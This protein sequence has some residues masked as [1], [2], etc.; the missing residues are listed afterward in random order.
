MVPPCRVIFEGHRCTVRA[1]CRLGTNSSE[2]FFFG[3]NDLPSNPGYLA[4]LSPFGSHAVRYTQ[5]RQGADLAWACAC[6]NANVMQLHAFCQVNALY[7]A[8]S[9]LGLPHGS[10]RAALSLGCATTPDSMDHLLV[11]A[12]MPTVCSAPPLRPPPAPL[13]CLR[14][15]AQIPT[16]LPPSS[17]RHGPKRS[18]W[19]KLRLKCPQWLLALLAL[20]PALT[21]VLA[22]A[23]PSCDPCCGLSV[24][25]FH[26]M[27]GCVQLTYQRCPCG[28][29]TNCLRYP[30]VYSTKQR[31]T[32]GAQAATS[33]ATL[34]PYKSPPSHLC[35]DPTQRVCGMHV[36]HIETSEPEAALAELQQGLLPTKA[37]DAP[38]GSPCPASACI[39]DKTSPDHTSDQPLQPLSAAT[40][41]AEPTQQGISDADKQRILMLMAQ[42]LRSQSCVW[43]APS[44]CSIPFFS[45][46]SSEDDFDDLTYRCLLIPC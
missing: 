17:R 31:S 6:A 34:S 25:W 10:I 39:Q 35:S 14:S 16:C 40:V 45:Q 38:N 8:L 27:G 2:P 23:N 37:P 41:P 33:I 13:L 29:W 5:L 28:A 43:L 12:P 42:V 18:E 3:R 30:R 32:P 20:P 44:P 22:F 11:P 46:E 36:Q 7:Q 15:T 24:L 9:R 4:G 1:S 26:H 21:G 19:R